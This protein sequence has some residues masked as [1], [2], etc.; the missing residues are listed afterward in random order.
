MENIIKSISNNFT[1]KTKIRNKFRDELNRYPEI[2][3]LVEMYDNPVFNELDLL[4]LTYKNFYD[5]FE[6]YYNEKYDIPINNLLIRKFLDLITQ[7]TFRGYDK[8][9]LKDYVLLLKGNQVIMKH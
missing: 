1:V 7:F 8:D 5:P 3:T 6:T 9:T 4:Q 2:P